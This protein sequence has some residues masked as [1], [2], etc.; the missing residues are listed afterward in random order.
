MKIVVVHP[1]QHFYGG[2]EEVV[3]RLDNWLHKHNYCYELV[4]KDPPYEMLI[5]LEGKYS[6][7]NTY[8]GMW[9]RVNALG[10]DAIIAFNFPASLTSFPRKKP[11]LWYVNEPPELFSK[12]W[13][14]PLEKFNKW[15]VSHP[16]VD[17]VVATTYDQARFQRLYGITPTII[18]YGIDFEWWSEKVYEP[19]TTPRHFLNLL[20][21]GTVT[22]LKNQLWSLQVLSQ[23]LDHMP[24]GQAS[25]ASL[26][27]IG[28]ASDKSYLKKL[29]RYIADWDLESRVHF[30]GQ[31]NREYVRR[32]YNNY[33]VLLHPVT[34]QG[35]WLAPLE[36]T[37]AKLPVITIP[38]FQESQ[39]FDNVASSPK[40]AAQ[41]CTTIKGTYDVQLRVVIETELTW[42]KYCSQVVQQLG[43]LLSAKSNI[44]S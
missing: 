44:R 27:L 22:P 3:V 43:G 41:I 38:E 20:Q 24:D 15:W 16:F 35:G 34:G 36:A 29:Q 8:L 1:C 5:D 39:L 4:L 28:D 21:V 18:S 32:A 25:D 37:C 11:L 31:R 13:R 2:A 9:E 33:D 30:L 7:V 19:I 17:M 12:W 23:L 42:D 40:H 10:S 26:T 14:K 6:T